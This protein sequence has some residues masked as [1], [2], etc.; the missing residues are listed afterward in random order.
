MPASVAIVHFT[1]PPIGGGVERVIDAHA[2][3]LAAAGHPVRIVAGRGRPR[4]DGVRFV[5]ITLADTRHPT[6]VRQREQLA[7]GAIPADFEAT[8]DRLTAELAAALEGIDVTIAHNVA[9]L[10]MNLA[11]TAALH[12]L[13]AQT[14]GRGFVA[15]QHDVGAAMDR[16]RDLD[17]PGLPWSLT[18]VAWPG[19]RYVA[20][21]AARARAVASAAGT[22]IED[23]LVI[24]N[25][26]DIAHAMAMSPSTARLVP[27]LGLDTGGPVL[28]MSAR[29]TPRKNL[30]L[31]VRILA[32]M[33]ATGAPARLVITG[34]LDP[35]D[36]GAEA[37]RAA[38]RSLGAALGVGDAVH[39][40]SDLVG[41]A[42]SRRLVDDLYRA[43]D[44][45]LITSRDEGFGL[46]VLEAGVG[47]LP[48]FCTD[49]PALR[50][51]AGPD[52]VY[53]DPDADP[54]RLAALILASLAADRAHRLVARIRT[55]YT[56]H[57][58]I[59]DRLIPLVAEVAG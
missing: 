54:V 21:S 12:R 50:E 25:G 46:P 48:I 58:I 6:I 29:M 30:E 14:G 20:V 41:H 44:A 36:P 16:Y 39:I 35:H 55:T 49:L 1:A 53:L 8:V 2:R 15:W 57:R 45:L 56:W 9:A 32:A 47:R 37:H 24:P 38:V 7:A 10:P 5:R 59:A 43:A 26:V 23:V 34:T 51:V 22:R 40:V 31:G 33:R 13:A 11:L 19:L 52:A 18:S 42:P 28:L 17:R 4:G 3:G 27:V